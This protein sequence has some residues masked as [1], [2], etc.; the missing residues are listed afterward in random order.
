MSEDL[1]ERR[2][3][4]RVRLEELERARADRAE[5]R[6]GD[7]EIEALE[8][9]VRDAEALEKIESEH[10]ALDVDIRAVH[11]IA[12]LVVVRRVEPIV[13]RKF[14]DSKKD[15][16]GQPTIQALEQLSRSALVYPDRVAFGRMCDEYSKVITDTANAACWLHGWGR[17]A[18]EKK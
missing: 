12:G 17:E 15:D 2:R 9:D 16:S 6:A 11:T 10:G 3:A 1:E 13:M 4:A 18:Q 5:A 7:A 8:R 14:Q